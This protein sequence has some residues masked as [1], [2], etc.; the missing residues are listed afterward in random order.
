LVADP[1]RNIYR[2]QTDDVNSLIDRTGCYPNFIQLCCS[3][4]VGS[5]RVSETRTITREDID[6]A[7]TGDK[8]YEEVVDTYFR[9]LSERC[10]VAL[11]LL[12]SCYDH[13]LGEIVP[14][15]A[16]RDRVARSSRGKAQL[17]FRSVSFSRY[18]LHRIVELHGIRLKDSQLS[19]IL[20]EL[21][22]ASVIK[23]VP[24]TADYTFVLPE[25]P[26]IFSKRTEVLLG[27]VNLLEE[28]EVDHVF[29]KED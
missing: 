21:V 7:L 29:S 18:D 22:L 3:I 17:K 20:R 1:F 27:A 16:E 24:A 19:G 2:I 10:R 13:V 9:N 28:E 14:D 12:V 5:S 8:L 11:Y 26:S 15:P 4:L 23:A 25:L 6:R